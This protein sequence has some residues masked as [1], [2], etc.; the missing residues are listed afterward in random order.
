VSSISSVKDSLLQSKIDKKLT[1]AYTF[2]KGNCL[3]LQKNQ[4]FFKSATCAIIASLASGPQPFQRQGCPPPEQQD[5]AILCQ[6]NY[7]R[8]IP[9][10]KS[11]SRIDCL[12]PR[13]QPFMPAQPVL[14][15]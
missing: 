11:R 1:A 14:A 3:F 12:G 6:T 8:P 9:N 13:R 7:L 10:R 4:H 5:C 2:V 15:G